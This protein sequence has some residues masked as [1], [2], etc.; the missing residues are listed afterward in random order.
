MSTDMMKA[1]V[2]NKF[3]PAENFEKMEVPKPEVKPG[4]LL[5]KVRATSV[6][7]VDYKIRSGLIKGIAPEKPSILH[8][9]VSGIVEE[10]GKNVQGFE[11][12]DKIYASG[13]GMD[14]V[15]GALADYMLLDARFA[16]KKPESIS[17][18]EAA[19]LPLVSITAWE[20]L[21]YKANVQ[22]DQQV[23]VHGATGGVGHMALQLAKWKGAEVSATASSQEK[24]DIGH[25]L[26]AD[27]GINYRTE[28]VKDYV[29]KY[30]NGKGYDL[31][32]DTVGGENLRNCFEA[33]RLNGAVIGIAMRGNHDLTIMHQKGLSL[34]VV[35]MPLPLL[36]NVQRERH[37]QILTEIAKL[38]DNGDIRPLIDEQA[39]TFEEISEAHK[40][41]E[42]GK[43]IGKIV[44]T[45]PDY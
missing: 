33:A 21:I 36:H 9:D 34:H 17:L 3:G 14:G 25:D 44:V 18:R 45:H 39:F 24:L 38:V 35:F 6:N 43:Q 10:A 42:A 23:L 27:N 16:A 22:P 28:E 31:V 30:T 13:G 5:V 11:K 41:V 4:H 1:W 20:G 2:I 29:Q 26:G 12:G 8:M 7:P 40:K 15:Q 32:F 19:A 37:G